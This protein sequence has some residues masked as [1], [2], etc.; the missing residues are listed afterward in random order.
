MERQREN[1]RIMLV[2]LMEK[3]NEY[4]EAGQERERSFRK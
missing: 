2:E 4:M 1:R 3:V